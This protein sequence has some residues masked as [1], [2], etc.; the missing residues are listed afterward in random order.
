MKKGVV[1]QLIYMLVLIAIA[2]VVG[3]FFMN[4]VEKNKQT[5][6]KSAVAQVQFSVYKNPDGT[7][8]LRTSQDPGNYVFNVTNGTA[9]D[10]FDKNNMDYTGMYY[11]YVTTVK[12]SSDNTVIK[13]VDNATGN[14]LFYQKRC[15][16]IPTE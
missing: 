2:V 16:E 6:A 5:A 3:L 4:I 14:V 12:C 8:T 15:S 1:A 13:I 9:S 11:Q 10:V 7:L